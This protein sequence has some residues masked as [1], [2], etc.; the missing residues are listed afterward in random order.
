MKRVGKMWLLGGVSL[1]GLVMPWQVRANDSSAVE[2][3]AV[4]DRARAAERGGPRSGGEVRVA[5]GNASKGADTA[6]EKAADKAADK[7]PEKSA[8][9]PENYIDKMFDGGPGNDRLT[10]MHAA[11]ADLLN[12]LRSDGHYTQFVQLAESSGFDKTLHGRGPFTV[13]VPTDEA[14]AKLPAEMRDRLK[15]DPTRHRTLLA[16]HVIRGLVSKDV[17]NHLRNV[18]TMSGSVVNVDYTSGIRINRAH[19]VSG[20]H[21]GNNGMFHAI[22]EMLIMPERPAQPVKPVAGPR[23]KP[24]RKPAPTS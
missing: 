15:Q 1:L 22:D 5:D 19:I 3:V 4:V 7:G 23:K 16:Y 18:K 2:T 8:D 12:V 21:F 17:L 9:K 24:L 10:K 14:F 20:D 13:F 11:S 6:S